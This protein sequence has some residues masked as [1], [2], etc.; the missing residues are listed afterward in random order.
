MAYTPD[1]APPTP[2]KRDATD[3]LSDKTVLPA[4]WEL[5]SH[6]KTE[7]TKKP[8]HSIGDFLTTT[9]WP[10]LY[11]YVK[12]RF[13]KKAHYPVYTG[14]NTGLYTLPTTAP[15]RLAIT[16][17][18]ATDTKESHAI[19]RAMN[20]HDPDYT[21]HVG[22]TYFVGAPPEIQT[23]F[24]AAGSPWVRGKSG[25]FAVLGNHEMYARGEAF[26]E[27]LLPSLGVTNENGT[28]L[29]Q[30]TGFFC[31]QN[32]HW[33]ILGL[34]T[35]YHSVGI[36]IIEFLPF[37]A[38]K[39]G[40][41]PV[42]ID[43]LRDV[44]KLGDPTDKRG[45][46]VL[47]H[48]QFVSAFR[49]ETEYQ[50]PA[51]QL[52]ALFGEKKQVIWL[53]GHEHKLAL[54]QAIQEGNLT[55]YGRCIGHGGTP[56]ELTSKGFQTD[57]SQRGFPALV[58]VDDRKRLTVGHTKLGH[59]G[60]VLLTLDNRVLE[61]AAYDETRCLLT[62]RWTVDPLTGISTGEITVEPHAPLAP[63]DGKN[64]QDAVA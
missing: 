4:R 63:V 35:G 28:Y 26:F 3:Y 51:A 22:D 50:K 48:H 16:S 62:E 46:V 33:R 20:H 2:P 57:P 23:N 9:L 36:P 5:V 32:D 61:I 52:A 27:C 19:A 29:G 37:G 13:G 53:W 11:H 34:D 8:S 49:K 44:V 47:T 12:S 41:D 58:A 43:W 64:W 18:W 7:S 42:L 55:I 38:P 60:Y 6:Y 25:S 45:I 30:E 24:L 54:Y 17:D 31:L 56:V 1:Q 40:F 59:N 39:C 21:I 15:S 10:W 14:T